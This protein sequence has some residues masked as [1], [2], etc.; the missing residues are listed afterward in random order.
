M[1]IL[2]TVDAVGGVW[3]YALEL[4]G[5]LSP[6][7][8]EV[9]LATMG[10]RLS[11][12]Q[13]QEVADSAVAGV[14]ESAYPLEW[15]PEPWAG[16][17][18]AGAWLLGL[19]RQVRPDV[20]H[21]NGYVHAMLPWRAPTVVAAHSDVLSWWRAVH[22]EP[23]P[24]Q[25]RAY[26]HRVHGGLLAAGRVVAPTAAVAADLAR[27]YG[28]DGV[29]VIPNCRRPGL[30]PA[31]AKEPL[32][33]A[34]GR[35]WDEAKNLVALCRVAPHLDAPIAVAGDTWDEPMP[36]VRM[37]GPL[38]F[39]ELAGWMARAAVF[40]APAR[41]EPFGLGP[42]EA[43]QAGCALV[44]GD[45]PSLREVWGAAATYVRGDDGLAAHLSLLTSDLGEAG[46]RGRAARERARRYLPERT[47]AGYLELYSAI[48]AGSAGGR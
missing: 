5:A 25:W 34:A 2:M 19:E 29:T 22:G 8:V 48:P 43:A 39:P 32:V 41:Y 44:L 20:V 26:R 9:H 46:R 30:M 36:G 3:T 33:L 38:P 45:I 17:N 11:D 13:R 18:E 14:H 24:A 21:L 15:M 47:A 7:G 6:H 16:V 40:A 10:P 23:A 37:L 28:V 27:E 1:R 12:A 42:L 31:A 35:V 4:A